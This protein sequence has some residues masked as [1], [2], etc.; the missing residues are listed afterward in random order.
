MLYI[1]TD[2]YAASGIE[3][4]TFPGGEPHANVP[5]W[6]SRVV[7]IFAKVRHWEDLGWLSAVGDALTSQGVSVHVFMPYLPGARQD[8]NTDGLTPLTPRIYANALYWARTITCVDPH[9][10]AAQKIYSDAMTGG[11][12]LI[13]MDVTE[14]LA[15]LV[16]GNS[17]DF[18]LCPDK[19]ALG[20]AEAAAARLGVARVQHAE[21]IRDYVTGKLSGFRVPRLTGHGLLVDDICDGGGTFVGIDEARRRQGSDATLDL[22]VAHGI[23]SKGLEPLSGFNHIY[24]TNSFHQH[25]PPDDNRLTVADLIPYYFGGLTP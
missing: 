9:S 14:V 10:R 21:K 8:R 23:F 17:Y 13:S 7:H 22:F 4:F 5:K 25:Y 3:V 2:D 12:R 24:T 19:G 16:H 6:S 20:R 18:I 15:D 1:D 11:R